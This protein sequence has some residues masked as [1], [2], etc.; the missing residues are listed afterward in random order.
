MI[1]I[2]VRISP[3]LGARMALDL[4]R[5]PLSG[6]IKPEQEKFLNSA[7]KRVLHRDKTKIQTYRWAGPGKR[8]LLMHGWQ[9]NSSR[10]SS[11]IPELRKNDYDI[12]AMDAPGHGASGGV[13]FDAY[14]YAL[15]LEVVEAHFA[16]EIIIAHSVG[17]MS[18]LYYK[19]HFKSEGIRKIIALGPPNRLVDLTAVFVRILG[20]S[21]RT[22]KAYDRQF[23]DHF[24]HDQEYYNTADFVKKIRIPGA[25]IHDRNDPLNKYRDGVAI[26]ENWKDA[27]LY[28]TNRLGHSLQ[29]PEVYDIVVSELNSLSKE[30]TK[31]RTN[32]DA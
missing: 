5:Y 8:V 30:P 15:F 2:I 20:F 26:A 31:E 7:E 16:P 24:D 29:S 14:R 27:K 1:N 19:S 6:K 25:I 21:E 17:A 32:A 4:F 3:K 9:S 12:M 10:W 11:M 18:A 28:T 13:L 22:R 23:M